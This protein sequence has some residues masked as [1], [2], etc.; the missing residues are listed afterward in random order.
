VPQEAEN[1]RVRRRRAATAAD[2]NE[3]LAFA[4]D[5][6]ADMLTWLRAGHPDLLA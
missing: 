4:T 1:G 6:R 5:L 3:L 2:A